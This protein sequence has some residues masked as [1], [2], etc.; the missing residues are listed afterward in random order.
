MI[1]KDAENCG[2]ILMSLN[3]SKEDIKSTNEIW[4]ENE[5]LRTALLCP[6]VK[7]EEKYNV[8]DKV[9]PKSICTFLKVMCEFGH[10][11]ILPDIFEA[12]D[13]L[14]L[15]SRNILYA[16]LYYVNKPDNS[17][18]DS[19]KDMLCKKY[20]CKDAEIKL[21]EDKELIGGYKLKIGDIEYDKTVLG[22]VKALKKKLLAV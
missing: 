15:A 14:V 2:K 9:F 8:I 16:E 22:T 1:F 7:C 13:M 4:N 21:I 17:V 20:N 10:L 19:F 6:V 3:I 11:D 12:Y 5:E 18:I